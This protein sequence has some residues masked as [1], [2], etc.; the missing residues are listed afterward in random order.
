MATF[1]FE[2]TTT[3]EV[4]DTSP[5]DGQG[6]ADEVFPGNFDTV[7]LGSSGEN[8]EN[9]EFDISGF[10]L[11]SQEIIT[12]ATFQV[13]IS[14]TEV[15]GLGVGFGENPTLLGVAGYVGNGLV[16]AADFQA[17]SLIDAV[18]ISSI[19][20]GQ[21]LTFDISDFVKNL[22]S[23]GD[24]FVGLA[25]RALDF[26]GLALSHNP[27]LTI[28]TT[29]G[30]T[31]LL[32]EGTDA[33][34]TLNGSA[35]N[36]SLNGSSGNDVLNGDA[37]NDV[38][39]GDAG[40]DVL[41]GDAG[42]DSLNGS[43]GNDS[44]YGFDGDDILSGSAGNDYLNGGAGINTIVETGTD[45]I[46]FTLTNNKLTTTTI[47]GNSIDRLLN[48]EQAQLKGDSAD[49]ILD[50]SKFTLGNVTLEGATGNDLLKGGTGNDILRGDLVGLNNST[51][52][53]N[54]TL[55]GG[56][57]NDSLSGGGGNDVL[58]G[59]IGDD[60]LSAGT[61]DDTLFGGAGNDS[62]SGGT[63]NDVLDGGAGSNTLVGGSGNDTFYVHSIND[64][65]VESSFPDTDTVI[66]SLDWQLGANLENLVLTRSRTINGIG[67][68]LN[69]TLTGNN[70]ANTLA[71][72]DGND[73]LLGLAGQDTLDG[74]NG[75][76]TLDGGAGND[77]L[78]G[79][80]GADVLTGGEGRDNFLLRIPNYN[81]YDPYYRYPYFNP[82]SDGFD[83]ITDYSIADDKLV[84]SIA[85]FGLAQPLGILK[86][87][88]FRLGSSA[89]SASERFIYDQST[90]NLF[91]DTDGSGSASQVQIAKL[92]SQ[93]ALT[94]TNI[95]LIA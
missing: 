35:D 53:G 66:S 83:T 68:S 37:G 62:L 46:K 20:V 56:A 79:G 29:T 12:N 31:G 82:P 9:A 19:F 10:F 71:G 91:F 39:N 7:V 44:L 86:S 6:D 70:S 63:G 57:G 26:G 69:N 88:I 90:G 34:D 30:L 81:S 61:A 42:N 58:D 15:G 2:P 28:T 4:I 45:L 89:T 33:N 59:G 73:Q 36:D 49:N 60:T 21:V 95:V 11:P 43:S 1:T 77:E 3:F 78:I 93:V 84:V 48:I 16:D 64:I 5:F 87:N 8:S 54:D 76:D 24:S 13:E 14:S 67:N 94:N 50:A 17:G 32:L 92:S 75:N 40:N 38:L 41:N 85:E 47:L 25:V 80:V 18:D 65:I 74:G 52:T 23:N 22:V 51:P 55:D 27:K 72:R